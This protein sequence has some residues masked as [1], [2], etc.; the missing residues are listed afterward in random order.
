VP[1]VLATRTGRQV[2]AYNRFGHGHSD[3]PAQPRSTSF[4]HEE[5]ALLPAI[6][7][8]AALPRVILFGHSDGA[9]IALLA[10][11]RFPTRITGLAL[12]APHA[13]VEDVALD[14]IEHMRWRFQESDLR[15]RLAKHHANPDV[16]FSGW[17]DVWLDP[18]FREWNLESELSHVT[19]PT[20]LIQGQLDRY[21]T[22]AQLDRIARQL[23]GPV[24]CLVVPQCGHTPHRDQ[25][26]VVLEA[27]VSFVS[28]LP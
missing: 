23:A 22:L 1:S 6:L 16:V 4:M 9:S 3:P 19:C 10:A 15:Q 8:A 18:A 21:G 25:R 11:A 27:V 20:L 13:F 26:E 5:A 14:S 7:D 24:E 12:E 28:Q 17:C 2:M